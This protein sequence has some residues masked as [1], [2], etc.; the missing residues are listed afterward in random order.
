MKN[1]AFLRQREL[2]SPEVSSTKTANVPL[3][4]P[5]TL[6]SVLFLGFLVLSAQTILHF[7]GFNHC[8]TSHDVDYMRCSTRSPVWASFV[9]CLE[10]ANRGRMRVTRFSRDSGVNGVL[11]LKTFFWIARVKM[12]CKKIFDTYFLFFFIEPKL[13]HALRF[14]IHCNF[15]LMKKRENR[16]RL[17]YSFRWAE[18]KFSWKVEDELGALLK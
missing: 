1:R 8:S 16:Y 13:Q 9:V 4:A 6:F 18:K 10:R 17:L 7:V 12:N 11:S 2:W 5:F 14:E 3:Y 15:G